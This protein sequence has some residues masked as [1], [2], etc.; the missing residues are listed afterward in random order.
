[1]LIHKI[2][3]SPPRV[4][5]FV[6]GGDLAQGERL[7]WIVEGGWWKA[8][9]LLPDEEGGEE[10]QGGLLIS[11]TV[12]PGFE[13]S[14]HEFLTGEGLGGLVGGRKGEVE[15][16]LRRGAREMEGAGDRSGRM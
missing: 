5:S 9:Y 15:W 13:F 6:V 14:D 2:G 16:L 8:S 12:V 4:E 7:Q 1:M 11:E 10:S 3:D